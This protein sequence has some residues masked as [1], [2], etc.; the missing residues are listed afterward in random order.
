MSFTP[1]EVILGATLPLE[2]GSTVT[3]PLPVV[4][5]ANGI[6]TTRS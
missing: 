1:S 6:T 4:S 2:N 5:R 3:F